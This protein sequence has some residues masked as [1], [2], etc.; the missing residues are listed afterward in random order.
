MA[1]SCRP[2][3]RLSGVV[4]AFY[5]SRSRKGEEADNAHGRDN[6]APPAYCARH[7]LLRAV[8]RGRAACGTLRSTRPASGLAQLAISALGFA[9]GGLSALLLLACASMIETH[10]WG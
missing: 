5:P 7:H 6:L 2:F 8:D 4:P 9:I 1:T 10:P 3:G